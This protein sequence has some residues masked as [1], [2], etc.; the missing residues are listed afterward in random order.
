MPWE[1]LEIPAG[2]RLPSCPTC[3]NRGRVTMVAPGV[4]VCTDDNPPH[5]FRARWVKEDRPALTDGQQRM[6][7]AG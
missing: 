2:L 6:E 5:V 3:Q 4:F 1:Y 7:R